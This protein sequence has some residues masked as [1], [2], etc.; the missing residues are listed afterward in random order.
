MDQPLLRLDP[1]LTAAECNERD[2]LVQT[3]SG[4]LARKQYP[5][6]IAALKRAIALDPTYGAAWGELGVA[7]HALGRFTDAVR[8]LK[9]AMVLDPA[10]DNA[11]SNLALV[12]GIL[13]DF[14][15][16]ESIMRRLMEI[17][18]RR[19]A[20]TI[21]LG[22]MLLAKGDWERGLDLYEQRVG[23]VVKEFKLPK[24]GIPYWSGENLNGKVFYIQTEQGIGDTIAFSR[25]IH[26][27]KQQY[28]DTKIKLNCH[29]AYSNL[30]WEFRHIVGFIPSGVLWPKGGEKFDYGCYLHSIARHASARLDSIYPDPGLIRRRVVMQ[31][32][33]ASLEIPQPTRPRQLRVGLAWTGNPENAT[34]NRRSV[35]LEILLLLATDPNITLYSLQC[36]AGRDDLTRLEADPLIE[37]LSGLIENDLVLCGSAIT[38]MDVIVTCCT[39]VA[40][41]AGAIGK[42]CFLMLCH[43]P[44]W[45]WGRDPDTTPWYPSVRLFRQERR[46]DWHPVV[47]CVLDA[48]KEL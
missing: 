36:G 7:Y 11:A 9:R 14:D 42:P 3:A 16:A 20:E 39:S 12:K 25:Y 17:P 27:V 10:Y 29:S 8:V 22:L 47:A 23:V 5:A 13:G 33:E 45:L 19:V 2:L 46:G 30:L 18:E 38:Q 44:Y 28:P 35:P 37:D 6:A 40:H 21:H 15:E 31:Q 1:S 48:L 41:L 32:A 24:L 43:D 4:L 34:Q 26:W